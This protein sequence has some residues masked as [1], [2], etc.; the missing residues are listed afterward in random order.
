[1][2][3]MRF[4]SALLVNLSLAA[5][6]KSS[7]PQRT[8]TPPPV[9]DVAHRRLHAML[10]QVLAEEAVGRG[11]EG[12]GIVLGDGTAGR[13]HSPQ[14]KQ[15]Q[16]V[17][18]TVSTRQCHPTCQLSFK[19]ELAVGAGLVCNYIRVMS[20]HDT[21]IA[22]LGTR[23]QGEKSATKYQVEHSLK[24]HSIVP[25]SGQLS[26]KHQVEHS[27]KHHSIVPQ[28]VRLNI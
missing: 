17:A 7:V 18:L 24:H 26:Y 14:K 22:L 21:R 25:Q 28:S 11:A 10:A 19:N 5:R 13:C 2:F 12:S 6:S 15:I 3:P 1:M 16:S 27:L 20:K 8:R 9:W 4:A 23:D